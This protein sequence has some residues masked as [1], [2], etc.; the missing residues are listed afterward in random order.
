MQADKAGFVVLA[1]FVAA[2][3]F[4]LVWMFVQRKRYKWPKG[5]KRVVGI[6]RGYSVTLLISKQSSF[7]DDTLR[8][9]ANECAK[10]VHALVHAEA[11]RV[12]GSLYTQQA[13][14]KKLRCTVC[15]FKDDY[16]FE[17]TVASWNAY[18]P[19]KV[20]AHVTTIPRRVSGGGLLGAV[21]RDK[22]IGT[23]RASGQPWAHELTHHIAG[24]LH[25][26]M[27]HGHVNSDLWVDLKDRFQI[28]YEELKNLGS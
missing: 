28:L 8:L 18:D 15:W 13:T 19:A 27:D 1:L 25:G 24:I 22:Y 10:A 17:K 12:E 9:V 20:A 7:T 16:E 6:F 11:T 21:I 14:L 2:C 4:I 3:L 26:D 5:Y 23:V